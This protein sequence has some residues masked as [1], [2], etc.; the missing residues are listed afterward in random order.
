MADDLHRRV[1]AALVFDRRRD[2][3]TTA[4]SEQLPL[5]VSV[6]DIGCGN[7]EVGAL[8]A[9]EGR[10]VRGV[11]T[12]E[13]EACAIEMAVYDGETLPFADDEF[14]WATIVDVLHHA[15]DPGRVLA[16][17]ARVTRSGVVV[18]DHFAENARQRTTLAVMDWVGNRQYGV[19]RDGEYLSR[20][21]W[22]DVFDRVGLRV[23]AQNEQLDLYPAP[24][25]PFFE[26]GLHFVARLEPVTR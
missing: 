21:A 12:L 9:G 18:K 1:H 8:V 5:D 6:L 3:L 7:G 24:A 14:D 25:K 10:R 17:A 20:A 11:E 2:R 15:A 26:N 13:R 16:E 22:R 19:G 4:L 23:T